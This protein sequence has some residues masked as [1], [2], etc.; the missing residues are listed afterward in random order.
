[1]ESEELRKL[2]AS[3]RLS[4]E[5]ECELQCDWREDP[6]KCTF[7]ILDRDTYDEDT[8]Q[9]VVEREINAMIGDV[10][11]FYISD[12]HS[13]LEGEV[14]IMI[15][16]PSAR[17]KGFGRE[18]L[19]SMM[20]YAVENL[21]TKSFTSKIGLSNNP[22]LK[23]FKSLG[24]KE[25]SKSDVFEEVTMLLEESSTDVIFQFTKDYTLESYSKP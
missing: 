17:G 16:E 8:N 3:E 24:F 22:S 10:N 4:L 21:G 12:C 11:I 2:T 1:M 6:D 14:E 13:R 9:D 5:K 19:C 25:V 15:A 7:I 18:A 20:R 23:L